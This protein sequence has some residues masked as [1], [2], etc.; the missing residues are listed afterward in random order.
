MR[1]IFSDG[2]WPVIVQMLVATILGTSLIYVPETE[3]PD[4]KKQIGC[5]EFTP[6]TKVYAELTP[7]CWG[8][9]NWF[10]FQL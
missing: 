5:D 3:S 6:E 9:I 8:S 1:G 4:V 2:R 10:K 7:S